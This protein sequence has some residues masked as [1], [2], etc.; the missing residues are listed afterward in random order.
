MTNSIIAIK[1]NHF[2]RAAEVFKTFGY[3]DLANDLNFEN[4]E[5]LYTYCSSNVVSF[6][7][8]AIT[9]R[10]IWLSNSWTII[11][12][13]ETIDFADDAALSEISALLDA[14]V[15]TFVIQTTSGSFGF[16]KYKATKLRSFFSSGGVV[17]DNFGTPM[18]EENGLNI[19]ARVFVDEIAG[20]ANKLG[21]NFDDGHAQNITLKQLGYSEELE[22]ELQKFESLR[23]SPPAA[24]KPWWKFW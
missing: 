4:L 24:A 15:F 6:S 23:Q 19:N 9:L 1:G 10:G 2:D 3:I 7:D 11:F 12:D 21:I 17:D 22:K 14:E 5:D 20:L 16:A 18:I 8:R 13:P